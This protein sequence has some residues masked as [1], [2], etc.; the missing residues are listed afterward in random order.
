VI[1]NPAVWKLHSILQAGASETWGSE[2]NTA[3][4]PR[5]GPFGS[6][7]LNSA[8]RVTPEANWRALPEGAGRLRPCAI[9]SYCTTRFHWIEKARSR[10]SPVRAQVTKTPR[11]TTNARE[12]IERPR[13]G[14]TRGRQSSVRCIWGEISTSFHGHGP[15]AAAR[16]VDADPCGPACK[17]SPSRVPA[18]T[19]LIAALRC[20]VLSCSDTRRP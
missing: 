11:R 7:H 20:R 6:R 18:G 19:V 16:A 10:D 14:S 15:R 5:R 12:H 1:R 3:Y 13:T 2:V 17:A 4:Q 9:V 8:S